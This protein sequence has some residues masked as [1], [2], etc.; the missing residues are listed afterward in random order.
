MIGYLFIYFVGSMGGKDVK[1]NIT[2]LSPEAFARAHDGGL[3][4]ATDHCLV[5]LET[6]F[7]MYT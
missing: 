2:L 7:G 3:V 5:N 4:K 6:T 1:M